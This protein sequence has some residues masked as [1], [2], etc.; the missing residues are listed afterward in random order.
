MVLCK[1][2]QKKRI[3]CVNEATGS[4]GLCDLCRSRVEAFLKLPEVK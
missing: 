2:S 4:D 3:K 1:F